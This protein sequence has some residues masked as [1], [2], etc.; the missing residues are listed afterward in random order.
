MIQ[1]LVASG[2]IT[3]IALAIL[4]LELVLIVAWW[5]NGKVALVPAVANVLS[6]ATLILALR[7]ALLGAGPGVVAL[8]L[9]LGFAAH[10]IDLVGRRS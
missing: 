6:G 7:A 3:L 8:W 1:D 4:A 5:R 2:A 10:L 9:A